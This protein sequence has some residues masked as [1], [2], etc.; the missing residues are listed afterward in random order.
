MPRSRSF[1]EPLKSC[2]RKR[3]RSAPSRFFSGE[4]FTRESPTFVLGP[5]RHPHR[6]SQQERGQASLEFRESPNYPRS[7]WS[8]SS[9]TSPHTLSSPSCGSRSSTIEESLKGEPMKMY[10]VVD[11]VQQNAQDIIQEPRQAPGHFVSRVHRVRDPARQRQAGPGVAEEGPEAEAH[12]LDA[13]CG[14]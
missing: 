3:P 9:P 8:A 11:W 1:T 5:P 13:R 4:N 10:F 14:F 12:Q 6:S 7:S 2:G